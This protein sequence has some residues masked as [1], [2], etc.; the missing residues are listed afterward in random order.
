VKAKTRCKNG[1][2]SH[3]EILKEKSHH[4]HLLEELI[5]KKTEVKG[6]EK[7]RESLLEEQRATVNINPPFELRRQERTDESTSIG[8]RAGEVHIIHQPTAAKRMKQEI[9]IIVID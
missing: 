2:F 1:K 5:A 4:D 8:Q 9:E 7:L 3:C 6:L